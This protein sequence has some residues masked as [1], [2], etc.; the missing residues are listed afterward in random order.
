MDTKQFTLR[1]PQDLHAAFKAK[2]ALTRKSMGKILE[3]FILRFIE[4]DTE[5]ILKDTEFSKKLNESIA[6]ADR[7]ELIS[8]ENLKLRLGMNQ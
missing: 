3:S 7:G 1:I 4:D 8:F 2:A 6:Q 5:E